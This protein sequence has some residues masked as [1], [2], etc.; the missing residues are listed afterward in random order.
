MQ[1]F[2]FLFLMSFLSLGTLIHAQNTSVDSLIDRAVAWRNNGNAEL[3]LRELDAL[4]VAKDVSERALYE[5]ALT[6]MQ[7]EHYT[8]AI[9]P[10][11][12]VVAMKG[13]HRVDAA[14]VL[15][16]CYVAR[17]EYKRAERLFKTLNDVAKTDERIP[18]HLGALYLKMGQHDAAEVEVQKAILL[19]RGFVDAH[20]LLS[21]IL[22]EKGE[23]IKTMLALYY[24]L[25]LNNDGGDAELAAKQLTQLWK[26]SSGRVLAILNPAASKGLYADASRYINTISPND[27]IAT[28]QGSAAISL[29]CQHTTRLFGFFSEHSGD[30]FDFYQ[31]VYLDFFTE[32]HNKGYVE[33]MVYFISNA[34]W[35]P[36]VL[37]WIAGNGQKFNEFRVW[38]ESR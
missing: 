3:A 1:F 14:L 15:A 25:L 33:P 12:R 19:N 31:L 13:T 28:L 36:Q 34:Q 37:E 38:M 10:A 4:V 7:M 29:L 21:N 20:L 5:L 2:R 30:N 32:L 22:L 27:S 16:Q 9:A 35:H 8:L 6:H 26:F 18:Y 23:R 17:G 11:K 24:Y